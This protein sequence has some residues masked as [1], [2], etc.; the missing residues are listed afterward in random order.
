M[1]QHPIREGGFCALA[2]PLKDVRWPDKFKT[3]YINKYDGS[4]NLK[5]FIHVYQTVIEAA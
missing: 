2:A 5:E 4:N 3:G 1:R